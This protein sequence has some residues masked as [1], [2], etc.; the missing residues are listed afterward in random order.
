MSSSKFH[1]SYNFSRYYVHARQSDGLDILSCKVAVNLYS[2]H[3]NILSTSY[4]CEQWK[5]NTFPMFADFSVFPS[6]N[7]WISSAKWTSPTSKSFGETDWQTCFPKRHLIEIF[8][9]SQTFSE[10]NLNLLLVFLE[11]LKCQPDFLVY[12]ELKCFRNDHWLLLISGL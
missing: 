3:Q 2:H 8:W 10:V 7:L 11:M 4:N 5:E 9:P 6:V 12:L 1:K